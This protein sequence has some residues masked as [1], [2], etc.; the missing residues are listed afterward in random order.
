LVIELTFD[1]LLVALK[2]FVELLILWILL[3][4]ADGPDGG[5][6]GTNLV[7]ESN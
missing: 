4:G 2:G 1:L 5:S 7:L 3:N 6:F